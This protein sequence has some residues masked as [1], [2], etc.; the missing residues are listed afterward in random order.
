VNDE[1][2]KIYC[3]EHAGETLTAEAEALLQRDPELKREVDQLI[4]IQKLMSLKRHEQPAIGSA[5][6][7]ARAVS[8]RIAR[9]RQS[10]FA[11]R[12]RAW[13][14]Y[15]SPVPGYVY[16]ATALVVAAGLT[17]TLQQP[18]SPPAVAVM[19]PPEPVIEPAT[20]AR[21][22]VTETNETGIMTASTPAPEKPII[23][24]RVNADE[25]IDTPRSGLT[26]GGDS[27]V[28]VSYER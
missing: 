23:M 4:A 1:Q 12:F 20:F 11:E 16:A 24:L 15:E 25:L 27:S 28:P 14:A 13:F 17:L 7:C 10:S 5:E 3:R 21:E 22:S 9:D 8:D 18:G 2:L 6:R 26:F 19:D